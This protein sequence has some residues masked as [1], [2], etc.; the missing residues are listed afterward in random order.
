MGSL[1]K[2]AK[3]Y[4]MGWMVQTKNTGSGDDEGEVCRKDNKIQVHYEQVMLRNMC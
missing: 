2:V 1:L 4:G 3:D